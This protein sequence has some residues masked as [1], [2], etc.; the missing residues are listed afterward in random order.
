MKIQLAV[1]L[2]VLTCGCIQ[3]E[4]VYQ[5]QE[6]FTVT[7]VIDGDTIEIDT[8]ERIRLLGLDAPDKNE[9]C[10]IESTEKLKDIVLY[11]TV[12]LEK[13]IDNKDKYG[14]LLRYVRSGN[15]F[16]NLE[17]IESGNAYIYKY[18]KA[19]IKYY[20]LFSHHLSE[21]QIN[22]FPNSQK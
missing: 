16:I 6:S 7:K 8:G 17:M 13:D 21:I 4:T 11:E 2:I 3:S 20:D 18:N 9:K 15:L 14:R 5:S 19:S 22:I 1:L 12:I 10:Y